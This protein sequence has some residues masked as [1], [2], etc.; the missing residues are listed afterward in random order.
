MISFKRNEAFFCFRLFKNILA[1]KNYARNLKYL[2]EDWAPVGI[3][4]P[5]ILKKAA[6]VKL[7]DENT[8][9]YVR[10]QV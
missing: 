10:N 5:E 1:L 7:E 4:L 3:P 8:P 2:A 9:G 6:P